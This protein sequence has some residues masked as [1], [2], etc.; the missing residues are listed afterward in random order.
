[1]SEPIGK[2]EAQRQVERI[3]AFREQLEELVREGVLDLAGEQRARLDLHLNN[4]LA[5]SLN[6]STST[7]APR[8]NRS[9]SA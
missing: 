2:R 3:H 8:R 5:D 7:S 1:M 9:L 4:K 6:A